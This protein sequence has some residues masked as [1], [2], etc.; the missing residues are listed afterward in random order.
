MKTIIFDFDGVLADSFEPLYLLNKEA[1]SLIGID[2]SQDDYKNLFK[3]NIHSGFRSFIANDQDYDTFLNF[4]KNNFGKYYSSVELFPEVP[5]FLEKIQN[6]NL[7]IAS[8]TLAEFVEGLLKKQ[9]LDKLFGLIGGTS[10]FSKE[11]QFIEILKKFNASNQDVYMISDTCGDISS[12]KKSGLK[13]IA[14]TWGFHSEEE[15][16]VSSP[17]KVAHDFKELSSYLTDTSF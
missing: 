2:F 1:F 13:T 5:T 11:E 15:L 4:K 14:V 3:M 7:A 6:S 16:L 17:D 12:A 9:N 10:K 8:A